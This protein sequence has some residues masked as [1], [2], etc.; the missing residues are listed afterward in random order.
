MKNSRSQTH[1]AAVEP[2]RTPQDHSNTHNA[3]CSNHTDTALVTVV[4]VAPSPEPA[5]WQ[6]APAPDTAAANVHNDRP[7][8]VAAQKKV[9]AAAAVAFAVSEP[10]FQL[11]PVTRVGLGEVRLVSNQRVYASKMGVSN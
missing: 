3:A 11:R 6:P 1:L 5:G 9:A 2:A 8:S 4:V 10:S 7:P